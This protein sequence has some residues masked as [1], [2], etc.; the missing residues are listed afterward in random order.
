MSADDYVPTAAEK[1]AAWEWL[2]AQAESVDHAAV[3]L[4]AW[5]RLAEVEQERD[6]WKL[7]HEKHCG[8]PSCD[9]IVVNRLADSAD[10]A[11]EEA[12]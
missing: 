4:V 11:R 5:T 10:A 9:G 3:A 12:K 7:L 2:R 1:A 8:V 6:A